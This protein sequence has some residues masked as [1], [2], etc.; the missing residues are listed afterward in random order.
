MGINQVVISDDLHL[1]GLP[2]FTFGDL[3]V[4]C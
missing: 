3:L 2:L 4:H 1:F